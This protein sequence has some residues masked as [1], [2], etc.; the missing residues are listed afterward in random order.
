MSAPAPAPADELSPGRTRTLVG[1]FVALLGLVILVPN[2]LPVWVY[3]QASREEAV[4]A[5]WTGSN[6]VSSSRDTVGVPTFAYERRIGPMVQEC[7]V[8]LVQYR[9]APT[10]KPVHETLRIVPGTRCEDMVVLDDPPR[11]RV[12]LILLGLAIAGVGIW[13]TL[14][15][16]KKGQAA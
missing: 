11:E 10:G 7:R 5:R 1:L 14:L 8:P 6:V 9:H 4:V 13:L 3:W 2:A 12:P 16:R 15:A